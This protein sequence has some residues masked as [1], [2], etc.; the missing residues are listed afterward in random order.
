MINNKESLKGFLLLPRSLA[1]KLVPYSA[2]SCASFAN[3]ASWIEALKLNL[4]SPYKKCFAISSSSL[5]AHDKCFFNQHSGLKISIIEGE[6]ELIL[7]FGAVGSGSTEVAFAHREETYKKKFNAV[8][9]SLLGMPT[10]IFEEA[11]Q[12]VEEFSQL[13]EFQNKKIVLVGQSLGGGIAQYVGLK[14]QLTAYCFNSIPL[15]GAQLKK[16]ARVQKL[17]VKNLCLVSVKGDYTLVSEHWVNKLAQKVFRT[18]QLIGDK[19]FIPSAYSNLNE[20]H[21]YF[22]GSL[23]QYLGYDIRT[24]LK[25]FPSYDSFWCNNEEE[26]DSSIKA[27]ELN[28]KG[29]NGLKCILSRP[30]E[31]RLRDTL[32]FMKE[33]ATFVFNYLAFTVWLA[34]E[35]RDFDDCCYGENCLLENPFILNK[36][37]ANS[38]PI[39]DLLI[40]HFEILY[41]AQKAKRLYLEALNRMKLN[42]KEILQLP[43]FS[44]IKTKI[45]LS[46]SEKIFDKDLMEF[47]ELLQTELEDAKGCLEKQ[48]NLIEKLC[49]SDPKLFYSMLLLLKSKLNM[50]GLDFPQLSLLI[51]SK[52]SLLNSPFSGKGRPLAQIIKAMKCFQGLQEAFEGILKINEVFQSCT[53][54]FPDLKN[55]IKESLESLEWEDLFQSFSEVEFFFSLASD[56]LRQAKKFHQEKQAIGVSEKKA[57]MADRLV[58]VVSA[59]V[60]KDFGAVS[61]KTLMNLHFLACFL[62]DPLAATPEVANKFHPK[63]V[64]IPCGEYT[65][66]IKVGGLAEA[67]RGIAEGLKAKGYRV[68][69]I[70]PKYSP[71]PNDQSGKVK[72]SLKL[73]SHRI[74]HSFG[75]V[76]KVDRVFSGAI[77]GIEALFIEDTIPENQ[78]LPDHFSLLGN[79]L[80][81]IPDDT[82]EIKLKERF[83]YFSQAVSFLIPQI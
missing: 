19:F 27:I 55:K 63:L 78:N 30:I 32:K 15:A 45:Q 24:N 33:N 62:K 37:Q 58:E 17:E 64:L 40:G 83:A 20:T 38:M 6:K 65:G 68:V 21:N 34:N 7:V 5:K 41:F 81:A 46:S 74:G 72:E 69:L 67:V 76:Y 8:A 49:E 66:V 75:N 1:K 44:E 12:F 54:V 42:S 56:Q 23:M 48:K 43:F 51:Q 79:D 52:P 29:L 11:A 80:Y 28:L 82:D 50:D 22:M 59:E 47:L 73:T 39:V 14:H 70:M 77:N 9:F 13:K 61:Q 4:I 60:T 71:F 10:D 35:G 3:D 26:F 31:F 2:A 57:I 36:I 25:S 18:P 53:E 16:L